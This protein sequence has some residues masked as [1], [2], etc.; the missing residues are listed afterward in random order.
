MSFTGSV[1]TSMC[2]SSLSVPSIH[3][4]AMPKPCNTALK[5]WINGAAL[6]GQ[7]LC[8]VG[9]LTTSTVLSTP[10]L[11][12]ID[13]G[14]DYRHLAYVLRLST[15]LHLRHGYVPPPSHLCHRVCCHITHLSTGRLHPV[16]RYYWIFS[17]L[18]EDTHHHDM[19]L[20]HYFTTWLVAM[21][22]EFNHP[23][24][25]IM[26]GTLS[27]VFVQGIGAYGFDPLFN[28]ATCRVLRAEHFG[29]CDF[30][31]SGE[32]KM[33]MCPGKYDDVEFKCFR[34][35]T[36]TFTIN[37]PNTPDFLSGI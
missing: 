14:A 8:S 37:E 27:S 30:Y 22:A 21:F 16:C 26:L 34:R 7:S 9:H 35:P 2:R 32:F 5:M 13:C 20:H 1:G 18:M 3:S 19:H 24:S 11:Y 15:L 12:S 6:C 17:E 10:L 31:S 29:R 25:A 36:S 4:L 23:I 28:D 33:E